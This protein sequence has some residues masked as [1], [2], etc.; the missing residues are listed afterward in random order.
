MD[1]AGKYNEQD[2][3]IFPTNFSFDQI[4]ID[5]NGNESHDEHSKTKTSTLI[6]SGDLID[7]N[8]M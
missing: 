4:Q 3:H 5:A 7:Q 8:P 1:T 2:F 6:S